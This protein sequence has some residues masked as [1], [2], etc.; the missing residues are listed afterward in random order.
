MGPPLRLIYLVSIGLAVAAGVFIGIATA[1]QPNVADSDSTSGTTYSE[2]MR[3]PD[4]TLADCD[5]L[6]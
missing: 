3:D 6:R 1:A 4:T 2:C 5:L